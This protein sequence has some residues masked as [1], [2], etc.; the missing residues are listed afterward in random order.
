MLAPLERRVPARAIG[1]LA[2]ACVA[3]LTA[4]SAVAVSRGGDAHPAVRRTAAT[5]S[6]TAS[7]AASKSPKPLGPSDF[8]VPLDE[9]LT[10][11]DRV[12]DK[13]A[14]TGP[15]DLTKAAAIDSGHSRPTAADKKPMKDLGFVR[16][17]S[18]AWDD[19]QRTVVVYVYE[20]GT[21]ASARAFLAGVHAVHVRKGDLWSPSTPHS[22]GSCLT[23]DGDAIDSVVTQVGRHTFIVAAIRDGSCRLHTAV[24]KVAKAQYAYAVEHHA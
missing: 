11:Y 18:R 3:V 21:S 23:K 6:P 17:L 16:G 2:L 1:P 14:G 4:G 9:V 13:A 5:P 8:L 12:P 20:W 24:E 10:A 7:P 15:I 19:G 22:V